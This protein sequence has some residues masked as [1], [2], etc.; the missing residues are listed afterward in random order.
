MRFVN[1]SKKQRARIKAE[2][3]I[4]IH[5]CQRKHLTPTTSCS[6]IP[7]VCKEKDFTGG[8]F[9]GRLNGRNRRAFLII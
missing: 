8:V 4:K 9:Y 3:F 1:V 6:T 2:K 7:P 5:N